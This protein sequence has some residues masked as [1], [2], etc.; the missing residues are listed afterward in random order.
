MYQG[1]TYERVEEDAISHGH[2]TP[3]MAGAFA[4]QVKAKMLVLNHFSARYKGDDSDSSLATML[5]IERQAA[6][7]SQLKPRQVSSGCM[8]ES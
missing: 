3:L 2:S 6:R 8:E 4:S 5:R 1:K 7:A